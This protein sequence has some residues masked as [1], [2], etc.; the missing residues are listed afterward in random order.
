[1]DVVLGSTVLKF[2]GKRPKQTV[3]LTWKR[4]RPAVLFPRGRTG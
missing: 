1:M 4:S 2:C 3:S